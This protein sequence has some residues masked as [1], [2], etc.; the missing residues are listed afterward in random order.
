MVKLEAISKRYGEIAA[1]DNVDLEI[2]EKEVLTLLGP[3]GSG[4]T[5]LLRIIAFIDSP[6]NGDLLFDGERIYDG[7]KVMARKK[8]TMVF[9]RAALFNSTV[10]K[11]IAYGL[12]LRGCS[13]RETK[14]KVGEALALAKLQGYEKRYAKKL[15]GGEQQRV[16]LAR[17]LALNTQLLLLDEPTANL[18]PKNASIIEETISFV[19]REFGTTIV[20]A[21]HNIFQAEILTDRVGLLLAGRLAQVGPPHEVLRGPSTGLAS[22]ARLENIFSGNSK[23]LPEG[24]SIIEADGGLKIE[25]AT[26]KSGKVT[27]FVMPE[28]IIVSE[29][30]ILSSARNVFRG[31]IVDVSDL[32]S[33]VK[34][35]VAARRDFVVQVTKRSFVEM[36]L[37][38]GSLVFLTFKASSVHHV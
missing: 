5:T 29:R 19:N 11:N 26:R 34:L 15:S 6:T 30:A 12:K 18:D 24:T 14:E 21:T 9:Q 1:L 16:S 25:S 7:N 3:N 22:F 35:R 23:I 8:C 37:N 36:R 13:K 31:K 4:K 2:R 33:I 10:Y 32:G 38:V 27:V 20:A 17:A 28:D